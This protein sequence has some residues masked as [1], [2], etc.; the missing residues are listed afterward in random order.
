MDAVIILGISAAIL[1]IA[2]L[3]LRSSAVYMFLSLCAGDLLAKYA[4]KDVTQVVS[5][6]ISVNA[7]INSIVQITLLVA[8]PLALLFL[9]RK[10]IGVDLVL[11][12]IPAIAFAGL[13]FMMVTGMLPYDVQNNIQNSDIYSIV[14]PYYGL[15]IAAGLLS[16]VFYLWAKRGLGLKRGKK[17]KK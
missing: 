12:L 1:G 11:Q 2:P 15:A 13:L 4:A 8:A 7:P 3:L 6:V 14:K 17:H 9:Y 10:R 5:S 16:S